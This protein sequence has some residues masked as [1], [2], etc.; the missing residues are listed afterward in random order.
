MVCWEGPT[1]NSNNKTRFTLSL[2]GTVSADKLCGA[3]F[4]AFLLDLGFHFP[5]LP[6]SLGCMLGNLVPVSCL[7]DLDTCWP[8][9]P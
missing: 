8:G 7:V 5:G 9:L 6:V 4:H 2:G 3:S 1:R